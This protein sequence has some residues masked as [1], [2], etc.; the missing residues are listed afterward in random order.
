MIRTGNPYV[1][2]LPAVIPPPINNIIPPTMHTVKI[3]PQMIR[4]FLEETV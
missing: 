2:N 4:A 1:R 3:R